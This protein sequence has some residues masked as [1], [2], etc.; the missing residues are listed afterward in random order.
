[1]KTLEDLVLEKQRRM[2][3]SFETTLQELQ[4]ELTEGER[5]IFASEFQ[6]TRRYTPL[7]VLFAVFLGT[8]GAHLFYL[9]EKRKARLRLIFFWT[10]I[11]TILGIIDAFKMPQR[12]VV[13]NIVSGEVIFNI[14]RRAW[15]VKP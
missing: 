11:P 12:V 9:G 5:Y 4:S 14:L 15:A 1:M 8:F 3:T 7:A 6:T 2:A 13:Y 10:C